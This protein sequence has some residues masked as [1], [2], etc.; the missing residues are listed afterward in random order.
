M[1]FLGK[2]YHKPH[3]DLSQPINFA[4]GAKFAHI[5]W[6]IVN[7]IANADERPAWNKGDFFGR[8]FAGAE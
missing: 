6:L 5:N 1:E 7:D 8:V 3:D 2:T 4:A